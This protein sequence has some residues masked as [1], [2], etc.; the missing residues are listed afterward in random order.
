MLLRMH[1]MENPAWPAWLVAE[2]PCM[3]IAYEVCADRLRGQCQSST[4]SAPIVYG[5]SA[6]N[7]HLSI[8]GEVSA[9]R[10]GGLGAA[11]KMLFYYPQRGA[12]CWLVPK[13]AVP[14]YRLAGVFILFPHRIA[15]ESIPLIA[16]SCMIPKK[17][18]PRNVYIPQV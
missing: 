6:G 10:R 1:H 11:I 4:R 13:D 9:D 3:P 17:Y 7:S 16:K 5:V 2:L 14:A 12:T 8:V 15:H 18:S